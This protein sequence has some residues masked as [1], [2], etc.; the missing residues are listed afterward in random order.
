MRAIL[1]I[2]LVTCF[3]SGSEYPIEKLLNDQVDLMRHIG[4]QFASSV[5]FIEDLEA[6]VPFDHTGP[7]GDNGQPF[8][9]KM[10]DILSLRGPHTLRMSIYS[11]AKEILLGY[12]LKVCKEVTAV[13]LFVASQFHTTLV[14]LSDLLPPETED[15]DI[16]LEHTRLVLRE[17]I[18]AWRMIKIKACVMSTRYATGGASIARALEQKLQEFVGSTQTTTLEPSTT[19]STTVAP[20]KH[21][22]KPKGKNVVTSS[23]TSTTEEAT[24]TT[25]TTTTTDSP[26]TTTTTTT[27]TTTST[28]APSTTST[29]TSTAVVTDN[30]D[31]DDDGSWT[32][33][34][35][36]KKQPKQDKLKM[37]RKLTKISTT[38]TTATTR[39]IPTTTTTATTS[40]VTQTTTATIPPTTTTPTTSTTTETT[41]TTEEETTSS[42]EEV[43]RT[44]TAIMETISEVAPKEFKLSPNAKP[45]NPTHIA[46][47]VE[48]ALARQL[49]YMTYGAT[50]AFTDMAVLCHNLLVST[51]HQPI[52]QTAFETS[53]RI[54]MIRQ[55]VEELRGNT[56]ELVGMADGLPGIVIEYTPSTTTVIV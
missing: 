34:S 40:T 23:A 47:P 41:T 37:N 26:S 16:I 51:L 27:I 38:T 13:S 56:H 5:V 36:A 18:Q 11:S 6:S 52:A 31:Q 53:Q 28:V 3:A 2:L 14:S 22:R 25:S 9:E 49:C 32:V 43:T 20:K 19:S 10:D 15:E 39:T 1:G 33:V 35:N 50:A 45:F 12:D 29:T 30:Q 17:Y 55:L 4:T 42:T 24:S 7:F 46:R 8:H 44:K 54:A 48:D 21:R